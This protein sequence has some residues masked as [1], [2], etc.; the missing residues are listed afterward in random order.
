MPEDREGPRRRSQDLPPGTS[1]VR[2]PSKEEFE[3]TVGFPEDSELLERHGRYFHLIEGRNRT[4]LEVTH[5]VERTH[6]LLRKRQLEKE[7]VVYLLPE[8]TTL[9]EARQAGYRLLEKPTDD[10]SGDD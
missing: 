8:G 3:E 10:L 5:F 1:V 7:R 4:V 2:N 6:G 9:L